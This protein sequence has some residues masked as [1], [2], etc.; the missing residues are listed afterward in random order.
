[1][2]NAISSIY[3]G[4]SCAKSFHRSTVL[5]MIGICSDTASVVPGLKIIPKINTA[6]I[7]PIEH[8]ATR[9]KVSSSACLSLRIAAI[10]TPNA[11]I[12]GT[13]IGPVVTPPESNAIAKKSFGTKRVNIKI[14]A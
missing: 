11:I 3:V 8:R 6:R 1:M 2:D 13:V 9:P 14:I 12:N 10:P 7:G 4:I 5:S